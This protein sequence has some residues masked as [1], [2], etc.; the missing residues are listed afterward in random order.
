MELYIDGRRADTD[1]RTGI[2]VSLSVASVTS[3]EYGRMGY[4]KSMSIPMTPLNREIMGNCEQIHSRDRFNAALHT[5]RVEADGCTIMEGTMVLTECECAASGT[6]SYK[7]HIIGSGKVWAAHAASRRLSTLFPEFSMVLNGRTIRESWTA[8][9]PVRF[10][11]VRREPYESVPGVGLQEVERVLSA[12]DYHP[13]VH[14]AS[15]VDAIFADAGYSVSSGFMDSDY[16]RSLYMSGNYP[17]RDD[18]LLK[19]RMDFLALRF[20]QASAAAGPDG[21]IYADPLRFI[22]STGNI[23]DTADPKESVN[24]ETLDGVFTNNGCFRKIDGMV[25]FVPLYPVSVG[26]EYRLR[27]I[28]DYRIASSTE[29][30]GFN[31]V[32]LGNNDVRTFRISNR[33]SDRRNEFRAGK[34]F[35]WMIFDYNRSYG[36]ELVAEMET[37]SGIRTVVLAT[38][39]SESTPVHTGVQG[40]YTGLRV[41]CRNTLSV[42][43]AVPFTGDW[44]LYDGYVE[45][46]GSTEVEV[47]LRSA[48]QEVT[49]ASPKYFRDIYFGGADEGMNFTLL[50]AALR[51]LFLSRP[52]EGSTVGFGD[53]AAHDCSRLDVIN[54]L[55]HMFNLCFYTDGLAG[56][57]YMEPRHDFHDGAL[58][59]GWNL[60]TDMSGPYVIGE[61]G[62]DLA[63]RLTFRYRGGD[64]S[65]AQWNMSE[66]DD[67]G[68]WSA[69]L[70][71]AYAPEEEKV[72]TN[73]LFTPSLGTAGCLPSAPS[74]SWLQAGGGYFGHDLNFVPR[75]VH[76][77]GMQPL[78]AGEKWGWPSYGDSYPLIS[79]DRHDGTTLCFEDRGGRR[80]LHR[81]WDVNIDT[82]N[83]G[84]RL[85]LWMRLSPQDV[86]ALVRPNSMKHDFRALFRFDIDGE[87]GDWR[88]EEVVDYDPR[89]ASTKCIFIK[90]V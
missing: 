31:T 72:Y 69:A 44:A 10:L 9:T 8:D 81:F 2:S 88:L 33:F 12:S 18:S 11:P 84:R 51:P 48:S 27:Y 50:D 63:R 52:T 20:G 57:V 1:P 60:R 24:G 86:E 29:L 4:S 37:A 47:V 82:Y 36:Y 17:S 54:A 74:A 28:T 43:P 59:A 19:E 35:K 22:N 67:L 55:R 41:M 53:V 90:E 38:A 25:A 71:N 80:G 14:V 73:P 6:G 13:F 56:K 7:F 39:L 70:D 30:A 65:V 40:T 64:R 61:L 3:P 85:T 77:A 15:V 89:A 23:V 62:G 75:I 76:F 66:E 46:T 21:R 16:F 5:A 79:F 58:V 68:R 32:H 87:P 26:F 78:P 45:E 42:A 34:S 83:N 49:P